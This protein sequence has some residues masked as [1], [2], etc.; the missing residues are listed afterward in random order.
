MLVTRFHSELSRTLGIARAEI[1]LGVLV[2]P[3]AEVLIGSPT[4]EYYARARG[5]LKGRKSVCDR[6][7]FMN[8]TGRSSLA[9]GMQ[10]WYK[11]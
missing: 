4:N 8:N 10:Q 1:I 9:T 3:A 5:R 7:V 11:H 2:W 6:Y